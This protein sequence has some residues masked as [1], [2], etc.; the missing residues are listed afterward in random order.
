LDIVVSSDIGTEEWDELVR[1]DESASFFHTR[2]WSDL[3]TGTLPSFR[4]AHLVCRADGRAV[5]CLPILR[6][7]R[8]FLSTLESSAYG[9]FGGPVLSTDAP[10]DAVTAVLR[11]FA[12]AAGGARI[13]LA[14]LVDRHGRVRPDDLSAFGRE[15]FTVQVVPLNEPYEKL[16]AGFKPS[17]RNKIRKAL[18]AGVKV[19]RASRPEDFAAY[20]EL[21][22]ECSREWSVRPRPGRDFFM[23]LSELDPSMVQVWLAVHEERV[24]A[25]DLNFSLHGSVMNWG[26]VSSPSARKLAPNNLLHAHAIEEAVR[27]GRH[28]YD[29][30]G[31]AGIEGVRAFKASFGAVDREASRYVLQK[32]WYRAIRRLTRSVG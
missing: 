10:A 5:A 31:S 13:G 2:H 18:K 6:R 15:R 25:G 29:L 30:G 27:E 12:R 4:R 7:E 17:A 3:L 14:Q 28:T 16:F 19:R 21:H 8:L 9:T 26:N 32:S 24:I 20:F 1:Q 22:E 11:A 23:G